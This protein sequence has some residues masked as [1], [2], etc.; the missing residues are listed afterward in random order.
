MYLRYS[1][2]LIC[3]ILLGSHALAQNNG[4]TIEILKPSEDITYERGQILEIEV[5][6]TFP[7]GSTNQNVEIYV[8]DSPTS[9]KKIGLTKNAQGNY[10][11]ETELTYEIGNSLYIRVAASANTVG[12]YMQEQELV[13]I[14]IEP[15][16][17]SVD[18][19]LVPAPPY[20][21]GMT[22][23]KIKIDVF[24]PD[25][26]RFPLED[27]GT[28]T[29]RIGREMKSLDLEEDESG[30]FIGEL[31][32][33]IELTEDFLREMDKRLEFEL[34]DI[35]IERYGGGG[36]EKK[37]KINDEHPSLKIRIKSPQ[38]YER[39]FHNLEIPFAIELTKG[40]EVENEIVYLTDDRDIADR[41]E[42]QKVKEEGEKVR[43]ECMEKIPSMEEANRISYVALAIAEIAGKEITVYEMTEHDIANIVHLD[44]RFPPEME[45]LDKIANVVKVNFWYGS[46]LKLQGGSYSGTINDTPVEFVWDAKEGVYVAEFDLLSLGEGRHEL[47]FAVEG[48]E[49][50][51]DFRTV[52]FVPRGIIPGFGPLGFEGADPLFMVV[53][54]V[55][56][57]AVFT[58]IVWFLVLRK[59][60]EETVGELKEEEV[61]LRELL[62]RIEIDYYKRR[63]NETEYKKRALEYQTRLEETIAKIKAR[64]IREKGK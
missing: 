34:M 2:V 21:L 15:L 17:I 38:V 55:I 3:F 41:R 61:R 53:P 30:A 39:L 58:F 51:N 37:F 25:G 20:Y 32:Y 6:V 60:R 1:F 19:S 10:V 63:L 31:N 27:V 4:I 57:L 44:V 42:C 24:Y 52:N 26:S 23:E 12:G 56:A 64:K 59:K 7:S 16:S 46:N 9:V 35:A 50:E 48:I 18:F 28:P 33:H 47:E 43:F 13:I 40:A 36:V 49:L 5:K 22:I 45:S 62:R 29:L 14:S 8:A 54:I 11:G